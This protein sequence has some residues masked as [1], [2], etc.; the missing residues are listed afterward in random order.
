[1]SSQEVEVPQPP[2]GFIG[3]QPQAS[4]AGVDPLIWCLGFAVLIA[5][6]GALWWRKNQKRAQV[7]LSPP[8]DP[9]ERLLAAV[10]ALAEPQGEEPAP[11]YLQLSGY[12][13]QALE[14]RFAIHATGQTLGELQVSLAQVEAKGEGL[15]TEQAH[16]YLQFLSL[17]DRVKFSGESRS[18]E[19]HSLWK[20]NVLGWIKETQAKP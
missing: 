10:E 7:P 16:R 11:Y 20:Q 4:W 17:A 9:W 2:H 19:S 5:A 13:R 12:L 3:L 14:L 6:L 15:T 1:M 18:S 8:I